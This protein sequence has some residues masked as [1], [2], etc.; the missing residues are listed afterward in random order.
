MKSKNTKQRISHYAKQKAVLRKKFDFSP[1][2]T[3]VKSSAFL[4]IDSYKTDV[5]KSAAVEKGKLI[6]LTNSEKNAYQSL[7]KYGIAFVEDAMEVVLLDY[8]G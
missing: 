7:K 3:I 4:K 2:S 8:M 5:I 6:G 1:C